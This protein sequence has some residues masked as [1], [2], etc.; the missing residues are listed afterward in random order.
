MSDYIYI[1][2]H[3]L[4]HGWIKLGKTIN[5]LKRLDSFQTSDPHRAFIMPYSKKTKYAINIEMYFKDNYIS[6]TNGYEWYEI[7]LNTAIKLLNN[8]LS[9]E[10][11]L[12]GSNKI[13]RKL[14]YPKFVYA[15]V[16]GNGDGN[17][18]RFSTI[19]KLIKYIGCDKKD[20]NKVLKNQEEYHIYINGYMV[21][22]ISRKTIIEKYSEKLLKTIQ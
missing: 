13:D 10:D 17:I 4:F 5:P 18:K 16:A 11:E 7:E 8:I 9:K 2:T 3:P 1:I 22:R 20:I 21:F 14:L 15:C 12:F 19:K 6:Q